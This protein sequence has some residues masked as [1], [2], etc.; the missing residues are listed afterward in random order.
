MKRILFIT[1]VFTSALFANYAYTEENSG[2]I[3]MHGGKGEKLLTNK[4]K[5]SNMGM[6]SLG[7]IGIK[8]P[9]MPTKPVDLI[10]EEKESIKKEISKDTQT[11][12]KTD[13][14]KIK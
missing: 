9:T 3:D 1:I 7:N 11:S 4:S 12:K 5:F 13:L 6:N 2:K 14:K 8:K 10:K